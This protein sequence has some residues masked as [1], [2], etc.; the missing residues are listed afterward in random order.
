MIIDIP[1]IGEVEFPDSMSEKEINVAAK[2]LYDQANVPTKLTAGEVASQAVTN[3]PSSF[4]N[5]VGSLA[6]AIT[7]P[8]ETGKA[9]LDV[10]AGALQNILPERLVQAVG[11]DKGSREVANQVGR[12]YADRYGSVEGAK[13]AIAEDPAGVLADISTVLSGG[14]MIAPKAIAPTLARTASAIDP[15]SVAFNATK[16]IANV[17]GKN[18]VAPILGATTGAGRESIAQAFKAGQKGG[19]TAE[20]FRA[21][22]TGKADPTEVLDIARSNL[23]ELNRIKQTEYR[24]GMIDIKKDK[25]ILEFNDIDQSFKNADNIVT[26]KG[27]AKNQDAAEQIQKVKEAVNEWKTYDPAEFHTPEGMDALKQQ[28]GAILEKIPFEQK[29]SRLTVGEIYNSLKSTIQKQAPTYAKTM[30]SYSDATDQ[31]REVEKALNLGKRASVDTAV[32]KL[33]S[34]MRDNVQTNYGQRTK[35]AKEL[36]TL[37]GQEFMP[38]IAGQALSN[39]VPRGLQGAAALPTSYLAYGAGGIPAALGNAA[40]SSPRLVGE[41][42]YGAGLA[43]RGVREFG[44]LAPPAVDPRTYNLLLQSGKI[45]SLLDEETNLGQ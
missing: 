30:K 18:V 5:L 35:L 10:G 26:F 7:S 15:L 43:S 23:Q 38:G 1:K 22:L 37:G 33:Q 41:A 19:A 34:L 8:L 16:S 2:R 11:E 36:E 12:F 4:G 17:G 27:K 29:T 44:K 32:R 14:A 9:I 25:S 31:I 3:F 21:N 20:Q 40:L 45:K 28:V 24:S 6:T 39:P 13:R 42:T